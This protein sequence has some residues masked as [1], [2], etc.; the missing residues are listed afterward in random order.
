M[1]ARR[2]VLAA[3][4]AAW[5]LAPAARAE[6]SGGAFRKLPDILERVRLCVGCV[7]TYNPANKPPRLYTG[8]GFFI[9]KGGYFI[10]ANHVVTKITDRLGIRLDLTK[11][12][13]GA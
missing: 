7:G 3:V 13:G 12:W 8:T 4:L 5:S 10:T 6:Q 9:D 2:L 1:L 11:R